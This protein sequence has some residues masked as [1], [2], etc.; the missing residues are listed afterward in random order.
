MKEV[1]FVEQGEY[2]DYHVV[3]VFSSEENAQV[4]ADKI[5]GSDPGY[6]DATVKKH[7]LDPAID[8]LRQGMHLYTIIMAKDGTVE[9]CEKT[10]E[11]DRYHL[12]EPAEMWRRSRAHGNFKGPDC[13]MGS[14]W[15]KDDKQ[16]IKAANER[17][18]QLIASG[19][20]DRTDE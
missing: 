17:R 5:N 2:S 10:E 20:W 14:F 8:E 12:D 15:G 9:K 6:Y 13:L 7:F 19:E 1:W 4:I 16:A 18:A 3:G 11:L